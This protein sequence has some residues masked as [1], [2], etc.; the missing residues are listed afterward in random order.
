MPKTCDHLKEL[1]DYL[2][3]L[4]I[5]VLD[6]GKYWGDDSGYNIYF[7]CTLN[8]EALKKRFN[9]NECVKYDEWDGMAAGQEA[10]FYCQTCKTSIVGSIKRY[11]KDK[12]EIT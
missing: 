1:E 8:G 7:D 6:E 12:K 5:K 11:A 10:G 3:S 9:F 4:N 2:F